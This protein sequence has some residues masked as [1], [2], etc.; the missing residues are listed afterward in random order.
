MYFFV[1]VIF[2]ENNIGLDERVFRFVVNFI[3]IFNVKFDLV[4]KFVVMNNLFENIYRSKLKKIYIFFF[5][6]ICILLCF[7]IRCVF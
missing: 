3:K 6:R 1:G 7:G 5:Y 2:L 4:V